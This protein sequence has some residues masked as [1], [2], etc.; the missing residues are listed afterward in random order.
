MIRGTKK[1]LEE[2]RPTIEANLRA[3][4]HNRFDIEV[5]D[6]NSGKVKQAAQAEN[7]ICDAL[8]TRLLS[9][10]PYFSYIHYG[11]GSGSPSTADKQLFSFL[12]YLSA[13]DPTYIYDFE[14]GVVASRKL[15]QIN[16]S[17]AVGATLTEVGIGYS[18]GASTLVTHAMIRDMNGNPV[19]ITKTDTDI[20][21]IYATVY[22]HYNPAGYDN[23][24]VKIL[25]SK[26]NAL[27][28]KILAGESTTSTKDKFTYFSATTGAVIDIPNENTNTYAYGSLTTSY[29]VANKKI[30]LKA[31]RLPVG[32][33]NLSGGIG[34][35][36]LGN[37]ATN[38]SSGA[39]PR[40]YT[41]V[42]GVIAAKVGG[43]WFS[44]SQVIGEAIATG[45][46]TTTDFVTKFP[47]VSN[48]TIYVDG[49]ASGNVTV[50][51][52]LPVSATTMGRY[53]ELVS[54]KSSAL[55]PMP[56]VGA[57]SYEDTVGVYYNPFYEHGIT[58]Y[59]DDNGLTVSVSDDLNN[60]VVLSEGGYDVVNVP[61]EYQKYRYWK[62]YQASRG[63]RYIYNLTSANIRTTNIHFS[64]PPAEGAVITAD[65]FT[66]T[67][68]KDENHVFDMTVT[69]QLGEYTEN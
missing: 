8:W 14:N 7:V 9:G 57:N 68:A 28:T 44:G 31:D 21:N 42:R 53:F 1:P 66:K 3:S 62:L 61:A 56:E 58:S 47:F 59:H 11:T 23:G 46:G 54:E 16:E 37:H 38:I 49:V 39:S 22:I 12:G 51:K 15:A 26:D 45:D 10:N 13:G 67:I 33:Y 20:I 18:S 63:S 65:Y 48:A 4:I 34:C 17:T 55:A 29:D 40:T 64:T 50:D 35:V 43:S 6:S 5:V 2:K 41:F 30:I 27:L 24:A 25:A 60:W 52:N 19:S 69:I 36:M 32:S